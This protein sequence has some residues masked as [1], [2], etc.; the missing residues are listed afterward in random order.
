MPVINIGYKKLPQI[1]KGSLNIF[2]LPTEHHFLDIDYIID[3]NQNRIDLKK[4]QSKEQD[5]VAVVRR[6]GVARLDN[7]EATELLQYLLEVIKNEAAAF[8]AV[9][10]DYTKDV[11]KEIFQHIASLEQRKDKQGIIKD[12]NTY[13]IISTTKSEEQNN[14]EV[15]F[16]HTSGAEGNGLRSRN[17]MYSTCSKFLFYSPCHYSK[18]LL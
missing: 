2:P 1:L 16:W 10:G 8:A 9:G 7:R 4:H 5:T 17:K 14:C 13:L 3:G 15:A 12:N 6:G 11:L 18:K